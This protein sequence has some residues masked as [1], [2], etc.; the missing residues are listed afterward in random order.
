MPKKFILVIT[1]NADNAERI[2]NVINKGGYLA[3]CCDDCTYAA[4]LNNTN[5]FVI[6]LFDAA[7]GIT[8]QVR[9]VSEELDIPMLALCF[10]DALPPDDI[11]CLADPLSG[12]RLISEITS[13]YSTDSAKECSEKTY[14]FGNVTFCRS[15]GTVTKNG[16]EIILSQREQELL[17]YLC[18]KADNVVS[19]K[20]IMT[21]VWQSSS[22][23]ATLNVHILKLRKKLEDDPENPRYIRTVRGEGFILHTI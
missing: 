7:D 10:G 16:S 14:T 18:E 3:V 23:S 12:D 11:P 8:S 5:Q 9:A 4:E 22:E 17:S 2:A 1:K 20:D 21:E 6:I 19:K 13:L 15:T